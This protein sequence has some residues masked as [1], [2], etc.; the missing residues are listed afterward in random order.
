MTETVT[1]CVYNNQAD[2]I[3]R[4]DYAYMEIHRNKNDPTS[5]NGRKMKKAIRTASSRHHNHFIGTRLYKRISDR[6]NKPFQSF[7]DKLAKHS[8]RT[9]TSSTVIKHIKIL[10][11]DEMTYTLPPIFHPSNSVDSKPKKWRHSR[12]RNQGQVRRK[13]K[14]SKNT[15][16][17]PVEIPS[18]TDKTLRLWFRKR[19]EKW[20]ATQRFRTM[21]KKM[22]FVDIT[23]NRLLNQKN[24]NNRLT[25]LARGTA[26][27]K[28]N[29]CGSL[30]SAPTSEQLLAMNRVGAIHI[31]TPEFLTTQTCAMCN[32]RLLI[33]RRGDQ[34]LH[35]ILFCKSQK[36]KSHQ[37]VHRDGNAA[38]NMARKAVFNPEDMQQAN[39]RWNGE[40]RETKY[41]PEDPMSK[42]KNR[43]A[44]RKKK[45]LKNQNK[46]AL[47]DGK[48]GE[49][50]S[51]SVVNDARKKVKRTR[52][53]SYEI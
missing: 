47:D 33:V 27:V 26:Y 42:K 35:D 16:T 5:E 6:K 17:T 11:R 18:V 51:M 20:N 37:W 52:P 29:Y 7:F 39:D 28:S 40:E 2:G 8:L 50:S 44:I 23:A 25:L 38:L 46:R 31:P 24:A 49:I 45:Q 21:M 12:K 30:C 1:E 36:C 48:E 53:Q 13:K 34:V 32:G 41:L 15:N 4:V 19:L 14:Q 43:N 3:D 10:V 9:N 22:K